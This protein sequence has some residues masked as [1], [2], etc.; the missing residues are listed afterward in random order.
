M[1]I[2]TLEPSGIWETY[3]IT[4][5]RLIIIQTDLRYLIYIF[6]CTIMLLIINSVPIHLWKI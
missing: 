2:P 5:G 1:L 4:I 3:R 6:Y